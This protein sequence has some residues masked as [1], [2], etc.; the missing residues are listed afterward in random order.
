MSMT[1]CS[2]INLSLYIACNKLQACKDKL[3]R[4][5]S[6]EALEYYLIIYENFAS[7]RVH[8]KTINCFTRT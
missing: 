7:L 2:K 3:F 5:L 4:N 8:D 1:V 6:N